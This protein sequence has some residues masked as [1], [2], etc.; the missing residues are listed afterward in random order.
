MTLCLIKRV[1]ARHSHCSRIHFIWNP[2]MYSLEEGNVCRGKMH[3]MQL[4]QHMY[5]LSLPILIISTIQ[6]SINTRGI[7]TYKISLHLITASINPCPNSLF[8]Q[9]SLLKKKKSIWLWKSPHSFFLLPSNKQGSLSHC[10]AM[11]CKKKMDKACSAITQISK[12]VL[13]Y[14]LTNKWDCVVPQWCCIAVQI[15]LFVYSCHNKNI[16]P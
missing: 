10:S 8:L 15:T 13:I 3:W 9:K 4:V 16:I 14:I 6:I 7:K 12:K 2:L 5:H 1:W 11:A